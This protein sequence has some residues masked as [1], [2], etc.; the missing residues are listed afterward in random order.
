[1]VEVG[2]ISTFIRLV[3]SRDEAI[4]VSCQSLLSFGM[5]NHLKL[6]K[7]QLSHKNISAMV[8]VPKNMKKFVQDDQNIALLLQL[9]DPEEG[10][11]SLKAVQN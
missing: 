6:E 2:A 10:S 8:K 7:W 3:K 1:M 11:A 9:L 5:Q 4:Q